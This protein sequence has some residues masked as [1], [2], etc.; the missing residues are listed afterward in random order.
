MFTHGQSARAPALETDKSLPPS[1]AVIAH[2]GTNCKR[3]RNGSARPLKMLLPLGTTRRRGRSARSTCIAQPFAFHFQHS[4]QRSRATT[5]PTLAPTA[6][7]GPLREI[8][9]LPLFLL[10]IRFSARQTPTLSF[11][12]SISH[13]RVSPFSLL[14]GKIG[15][16]RYL[17]NDTCERCGNA[18]CSPAHQQGSSNALLVCMNL[19]SPGST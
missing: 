1:E 18:A 7:P 14:Y 3:K 4:Y 8:Q 12:F 13:S 9:R 19:C 17:I 15:S 10:I 16:E 2:S 5:H 6:L 11:L